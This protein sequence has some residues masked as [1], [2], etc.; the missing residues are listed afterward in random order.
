[1][2][3]REDRG[4]VAA[5]EVLDE[6]PGRCVVHFVLGRPLLKHFIKGVELR[7]TERERERE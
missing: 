4:V 3:V 2:A 7:D 5:E 6:R 1:M